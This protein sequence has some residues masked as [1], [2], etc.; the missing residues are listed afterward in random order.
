MSASA[1]KV[2]SASDIYTPPQCIEI[3]YLER[4][5]GNTTILHTLDS[6]L[7]LVS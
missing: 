2:V 4:L 3:L 1:F 6:H 7:D 5:T